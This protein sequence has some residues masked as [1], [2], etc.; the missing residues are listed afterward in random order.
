MCYNYSSYKR[1]DSID[2]V[3]TYIY[4]NGPYEDIYF[5]DCL[6]NP[7]KYKGKKY[8]KLRE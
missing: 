5:N 2:T 1:W 8:W 7:D 3:S 4:I 6:K